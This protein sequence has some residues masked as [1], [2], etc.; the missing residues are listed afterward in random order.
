M[1]P[2]HKG[3]LAVGL[4][5]GAATFILLAVA[6][7]SVPLVSNVLQTGVPVLY[8]G[9]AMVLLISG[10][11]GFAV[12]LV[13]LYLG[14]G[15]RYHRSRNNEYRKRMMGYGGV[16]FLTVGVPVLLMDPAALSVGLGVVLLWKII[17]DQSAASAALAREV[18]TEREQIPV[19]H[20]ES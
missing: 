16:G 8:Y 10:G 19:H 12:S 1:N 5:A 18:V 15:R 7:S 13:V 17:A 4:A 6:Y 14:S 11:I 3:A 9:N 2:L 20:E